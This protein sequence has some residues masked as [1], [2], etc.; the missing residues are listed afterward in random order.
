MSSMDTDSEGLDVSLEAAV[1][2]AGWSAC[3]AAAEPQ[4]MHQRSC[5]LTT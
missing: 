3:T 5:L 1:Q 4:G 2:A